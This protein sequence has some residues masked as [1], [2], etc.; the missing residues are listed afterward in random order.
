MSAVIQ[1]K[2]KPVIKKGNG[3]VYDPATFYKDHHVP[4]SYEVDDP[5]I[6][7]DNIKPLEFI[8]RKFI[9]FDTETHPHYAKSSDVPPSVVRRWVGK[10]KKAVPQDYPFSLQVS[11][12]TNNYCIYDTMA[13]NFNKFRALAPLFE[14]STIEKIAHNVKFDMHQMHNIS[15]KIK[16]KL[17]D[18]VVLAKIAN[19]NRL[20]FELRELA[21]KLPNGIIKFEYMVDTYKQLNH[22]TDYR[23]IPKELLSE[24]GC[25]DVWNCIHEFVKE[26]TSILEQDKA[27]KPGQTL[28]GIYINEMEA[29]IALYAMERRGMLLDK[30]YEK[31]L[32]D[33]LQN[34]VDTAE[35]SVY[36]MAGEVFNINSGAQIAKVMKKL[37]VDE[38]ILHYT[39]K[40]NVKLDKD[41]LARL[42]EI[43]NIPIISKIQEYKKSEKLLT[44]YAVGIYGQADSEG[45]AH[46]S[47]NQTEATTGRMSITKP[48]LQTL[49]KKDKRI[50]KA[51]V[52]EIDYEMWFMDLDQVE[53]RGFAH[54]A[55]A[56]GLIDAINN[57]YDVHT[58]TA[59]IIFHIALEVLTR[60]LHEY[61]ELSEKLKTLEGAELEAAMARLA[62]L[63]PL[64]DTR[65]KGKTI[66][67]AL[68]YG[69]GIDHLCEILHCTKTEAE[70]LKATYFANIPEA[71]PF[72]KTVHAVVKQKGY[73]TNF[74]GRRRRLD[75]NDCYKA[76]NALIQGWAAD[77]IKHKM[78]NIYKYLVYNKL[79]SCL[80][81]IVHDELIE[82]I[83]KS[84]KCHIPTLRWLLSD[85]DTYRCK[86]TA[87]IEY[88]D[89]SWGQKKAPVE[90][91]GFKEP[92]DKGYL[93][94]DLFDGH[95]FDI[96]RE[97][98]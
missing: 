19:E 96:G 68:I 93:T 5:Q 23:Q 85:F 7:L 90:D 94:V 88:G 69:V 42:D 49:P 41:E 9:S 10:G 92:E 95:V 81:N 15:M 46:G 63:Q 66:N 58:A 62:E 76:P 50:R 37:G 25:A 16:G 2:K 3:F 57:G 87:G 54:Y 70:N 40:G 56:Y 11:D 20:G 28:E 65:A 1:P 86:I 27:S 24:Y 21:S 79:K 48:A 6:I 44:T 30:D 36:E 75:A 14:D 59:G 89:P 35:A 71:Q 4:N 39:D 91:V 38:S 18:T 51:F 78:V 61:D 8:G 53:Y 83:H 26:Y 33:S 34:T 17:H 43:Y 47:I 64:V 13:N 60:C 32:K 82:L 77:Y 84:E 72:I 22:V 55:K 29:T 45:K 52:P 67:F 97:V 73:V 31:P 12:G 74:Y 80:I 98:A